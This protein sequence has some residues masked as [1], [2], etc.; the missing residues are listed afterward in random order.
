MGNSVDDIFTGLAKAGQS[1][2]SFDDVLAGLKQLDPVASGLDKN[3][4]QS[5]AQNIENLK[6]IQDLSPDG[7][8]TYLKGLEGSQLVERVAIF[9]N[10]DSYKSIVDD[11]FVKQLNLLPG[12]G[13][14]DDAATAARQS[15]TVGEAAT[16][17]RQSATVEDATKNLGDAL[18]SPSVADDLMT[19]LRK[20]PND[21]G[22]KVADAL[23]AATK[24]AGGATDEL[25]NTF[26]S[27]MQKF[28]DFVVS[29]GRKADDLSSGVK[30]DIWKLGI[31]A[32]KFGGGY[33]MLSRIEKFMKK[34]QKTEKNRVKCRAI[35]EPLF[36]EKAEVAGLGGTTELGD[37]TLGYRVIE[38][39]QEGD[40]IIDKLIYE[41]NWDWATQPLCPK[42]PPANCKTYCGD[43]CEET[44]PKDNPFDWLGGG[45]GD[46]FNGF[47]DSILEGFGLDGLGDTAAKAIKYT[48][49]SFAIMI[50]LVV[51]YLAVRSAFRKK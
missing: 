49:T 44:H 34:D 17:A 32:A 30:K 25:T 35:C 7:I 14:L 45:L 2:R 42:D 31:L 40:E 15:D 11:D 10:M 8:K 16:A 4:I 43:E 6:Q 23:A 50:G 39:P 48:I 21:E 46:M 9:R 27:M 3:S 5:L 36:W 28:D 41:D 26:K 38:D 47:T 29:G 24:K 22:T 1:T 13:A 19:T 12:G 51:V 37:S 33:Y 18:G 20:L